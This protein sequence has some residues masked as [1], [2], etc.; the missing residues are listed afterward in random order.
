[1]LRP[2]RR[3]VIVGAHLLQAMTH[4]TRRAAVAAVL[5]GRRDARAGVTGQRSS[6]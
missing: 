5:E 4:P 6:R 1:V 3:G 2:L